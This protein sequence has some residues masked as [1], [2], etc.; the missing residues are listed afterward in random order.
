[1][2]NMNNQSVPI[3]TRYSFREKIANTKVIKWINKQRMRYRKWR[4]NLSRKLDL[5]S[6]KKPFRRKLYLNRTLYLMMFPYVFL[7]FLFTILPVII[8]IGLSFTYF[9]LLEAPK[10]IGWDNYLSLFLD[11]EIFIIALRNT[12]ILAVV[13]GPIGYL[14]S[15]VFAWLIN[16]LPNKFRAFVTLIFYAPSMAGNAVLIWTIIFNSDI[17]G[18]A[19]AYLIRFGIIQEPITWL[20]NSKYI[21]PI[22]IIVQLWMS[23]GVNFLVLIAGLK[24]IDKD[25]YEAAAID[26]IKNRW[27]ELWYITLPNMKPQ[28]TLSAV[29][30]ISSTLGIGAITTQLVGFPSIEYAGHTIVNH[31]VDYGTIRFEMGYASAIA[32]ILFLASI[33]LNRLIQRIIRRV[34]T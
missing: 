5:W 29:L 27:Q 33:S 6:R 31:L 26:G 12:L 28:L 13:T 20:Q 8:S 3:T 14:L 7:F 15:F 22:I 25:Q 19:N 34:G 2:E 21:L 32:T 30:Q 10:F 17:Y 4:E 9:N 23:L 1:M 11:D 18:F 16:E 24:N